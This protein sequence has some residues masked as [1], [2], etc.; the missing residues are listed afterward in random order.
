[1]VLNVISKRRSIR[2]YKDAPVSDKDV[3]EIIRAGFFAPRAKHND[4]LTFLVIKDLAMRGKISEILKQPFLKE[5]PVLIALVSDPAKSIL[6]IQD[7]SVA[8]E[9]MFLE[10]VNLG[11][12]SVWKNVNEEFQPEIKKLLGIPSLLILINFIVVGI[13]NEKP[14]PHS[15]ADF[16]E[17]SIRHEKW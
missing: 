6:P 2:K 16:D 9:N 15:N 7:I 12:G 5:A 1:M 4:G 14:L 8:S 13:A 17:K 3:L 11:L 10:A